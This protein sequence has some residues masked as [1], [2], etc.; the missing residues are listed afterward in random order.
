M[1][2]R[3]RIVPDASV[4]V[5]AFFPEVVEYHNNP[6]DLSK[7]AKPLADAI[8]GRSSVVAIAP[9]HL[10]YE[11]MKSAHR[12]VGEKISTG[13][14]K[15]QVDAFLYLWGQGIQAEPMDN[16]AESAWKLST[17]EGIAPPPIVGILRVRSC[18]RLNYGYLTGLATASRTRARSCNK[19][20][21]LF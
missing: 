4:I 9:E 17:E 7:R 14:A 13:Q 15:K 3:R 5:P 2:A 21:S 12:K 19:T 11:F 8:L 1:R 6:F 10:I 20:R 18:T 16:L